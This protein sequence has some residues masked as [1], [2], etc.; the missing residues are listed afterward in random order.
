MVLVVSYLVKCYKKMIAA[1]TSGCASKISQGDCY[2]VRMR[3]A[4]V[5]LT[6]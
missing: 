3:G 4:T 1:F 6:I 5:M 2:V